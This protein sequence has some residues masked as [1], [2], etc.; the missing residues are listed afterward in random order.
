MTK[1]TLQEERRPSLTPQRTAVRHTA[2]S[3]VMVR[4]QTSEEKEEG[5]HDDDGANANVDVPSSP[6]F[7][8]TDAPV[9][10]ILTCL[11]DFFSTPELTSAIADFM[12][13]NSSKVEFRD[14]NDEQPMQNHEI[15]RQYSEVVENRL[16]DFLRRENID[17]SEV[18]E[19]CKRVQG[20]DAANCVTCVDYL[21][22]ATE[23]HSFM[24]LAYDFASMSMWDHPGG[25]G[26]GG[27]P[28]YVSL[29]DY[30]EI[31]EVVGPD[32]EA[33]EGVLRAEGGGD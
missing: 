23:Y 17:M 18:A 28:R 7:N 5:A 29:E 30:D 4:V 20:S 14:P 9:E 6:T 22:A 19:A 15:F 27:A 12:T 11:E 8:A 3:V 16:E 1:Y 13:E 31:V 25:E 24:L 10:P 33:L 26:E 2:S 21:V 32:D